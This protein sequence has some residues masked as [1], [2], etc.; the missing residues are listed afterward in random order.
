MAADPLEENPPPATFAQRRA[1]AFL[2]G[3]AVVT[4]AGLLV[5]ALGRGATPVPAGAELE[6]AAHAQPGADRR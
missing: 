3:L 2:G 6:A 5:L 4:A 1:I